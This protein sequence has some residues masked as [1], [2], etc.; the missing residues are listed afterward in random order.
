[1]SVWCV[2]VCK[3][4]LKGKVLGYFLCETAKIHVN[5]TKVGGRS[6]ESKEASRIVVKA[7]ELAGWLA[8]PGNTIEN[9]D[10]E[11]GEARITSGSINNYAVMNIQGEFLGIGDRPASEFYV[12]ANKTFKMPLIVT[13][14]LADV[15]GVEILLPSGRI[16]N[17]SEHAIINDVENGGRVVSNAYVVNENGK[18]FLRSKRGEL[19]RKNLLNNTSVPQ[20]RKDTPATVN[21]N[22]SSRPAVTPVSTSVNKPVTKVYEKLPVIDDDET[23]EKQEPTVKKEEPVKEEVVDAKPETEATVVMP[24][25][26]AQEAPKDD[27]EDTEIKS[28]PEDS[29]EDSF[30][31]SNMPEVENDN[32]GGLADMPEVENDNFGGLAD[33]PEVENDNFGGLADMPDVE[34]SAPVQ[35]S[36]ANTE[37]DEQ[38]EYEKRIADRQAAMIKHGNSNVYGNR[39]DKFEN[40]GPWTDKDTEEF[41]EFGTFGNTEVISRIKLEKLELT[42]KAFGDG[43]CNLPF[44]IIHNGKAIRVIDS[45]AISMATTVPDMFGKMYSVNMLRDAF[46]AG[47]SYAEHLSWIENVRD[48][49]LNIP[50]DYSG[51]KGFRVIDARNLWE[52][53]LT[54]TKRGTLKT[55]FDDSR[56]TCVET[57]EKTKN[58]EI[59]SRVKAFFTMIL[60]PALNSEGKLITALGDFVV[61]DRHYTNRG[62]GNCLIKVGNNIKE[63]QPYCFKCPPIS[64][65]FDEGKHYLTYGVDLSESFATFIPKFFAA[66][67]K[68]GTDDLS[69]TTYKEDSKPQYV[70]F[71]LNKLIT[72]IHESA[73]ARVHNAYINIPASV[74]EVAQEAFLECDFDKLK[75]E[76]GCQFSAQRSAFGCVKT[77]NPIIDLKVSG[78]GMSTG[79]FSFVINSPKEFI[80]EV[81][82]PGTVLSVGRKAISCVSKG[83]KAVLGGINKIKFEDGTEEVK[84]FPFYCFKEIHVP[85]GIKSF[86]FVNIPAEARV[87]NVNGDDWDKAKGGRFRTKVY[88]SKNAASV[89][90][91]RALEQQVVAHNAQNT[92]WIEGVV[93][94]VYTDEYE[95][96]VDE[97]LE[98]IMKD[99]TAESFAESFNQGSSNHTP[100]TMSELLAR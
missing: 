76:A 82:V 27:T 2:A 6:V 30:S 14:K 31:L 53:K 75:F 52:T 72:R 17:Y 91:W 67:V 86:E 28:E 84:G 81:H 92:V 20:T 39:F 68:M 40:H 57:V 3:E 44:P 34:N 59:L 9:M 13:G 51:V 16:G 7:D 70:F 47:H 36:T 38:K 48:G 73:F 43:K 37:E 61:N 100:Y 78:A 12:H 93:E 83:G 71:K 45:V 65:D 18:Q 98:G 54:D 42:C 89:T 5:Q 49:L 80:E 1:M 77:I 96:E 69:G 32:F 58:G 41:L 99:V 23:V 29:S 90:A 95:R 26:I 88:I 25:A 97:T 35:S 74:V 50:I 85:R 22:V 62:F 4:R 64:Y 60:V 24:D 15:G 55:S 11:N 87:S 46:V 94:L 8:K 33:M 56:S 66:P 79:S 10:V 63:I 21:M 19:D